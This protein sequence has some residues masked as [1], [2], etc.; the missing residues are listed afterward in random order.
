[1]AGRLYYLDALRSFCM[2]FGILVHA[3]TLFAERPYPAIPVASG[4]F[5]MA[6]FF[7]VSGFFVALV[8]SRSSTAAMIRKRSVTLLVPLVVMVVLFN[9]VTNYLVYIR[10]N[11]YMPLQAYLAGGW[12]LPANGPTSW[13]LHLW[14]LVSLWAYCLAFPLLRGLVGHPWVS[15]LLLR[16]ARW[17]GDLLIVAAA[18]AVGAAVVAMRSL[19]ALLFGALLPEGSRLMWVV[20]ATLVYLP[21]FALGVALF[22]TPPLF[23]HFHRISW[24]AL[25]LGLLL[26]LVARQFGSGL[27]GPV[28]TAV[29]VFARAVLTL[30]IVA[31]LLHLSRWLVP[32]E[33]RPV[34]VMVDSI[35]TVYLFHYLAIY[36]F[37]LL[38]A[39]FFPNDAVLFWVVVAL[40]LATTLA[41][42]RLVV[43]RVPLMRFLFN[44]RLPE[45]AAPVPGRV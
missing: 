43:L 7:V 27:P 15:G 45:T 22:A 17:Q 23:E 3:N 30:A 6:A 12:R 39:A 31:A 4:Y 5:R 19:D 18:L 11:E 20:R 14:F 9:P 40:T 34:A 44:G 35:Y 16:A 32:R 38:L 2:L 36:A 28:E 21:F 41:F 10:H 24:P 1:M 42:H 26:V 8:A 29:A 13:L 37:G 25:G 33:N